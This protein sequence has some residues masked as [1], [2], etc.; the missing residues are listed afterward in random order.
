[1]PLISHLMDN[2]Q[3]TLTEKLNNE[4]NHYRCRRFATSIYAFSDNFPKVDFP[5]GQH[6]DNSAQKFS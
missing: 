2:Q 6:Y 1:M 3:V 4:I 5:N